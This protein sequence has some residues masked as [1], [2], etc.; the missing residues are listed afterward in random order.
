MWR[1]RSAHSLR[2]AF[3]GVCVT[4]AVLGV[5]V[6]LMRPIFPSVTLAELVSNED[7]RNPV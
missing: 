4:A 2:A 3:G 7:C 5:A 1:E 6:P